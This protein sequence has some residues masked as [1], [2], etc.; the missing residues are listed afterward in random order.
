MKL[1]SVRMSRP[2][3]FIGIFASVLLLL[4]VLLLFRI[5]G[6]QTQNKIWKTK[7]VLNLAEQRAL[8]EHGLEGEYLGDEIELLRREGFRLLDD[9]VSKLTLLY[10]FTI[11]CDRCLNM[12]MDIYQTNASMLDETHVTPL[13]VFGNIDQ[14][15]FDRIVRSFGIKEFSIRDKEEV[16]IKKFSKLTT[17]IILLI[18]SNGRIL[19]AHIS[20]Y[21]DRAK[22]QRFYEKVF[23]I[24]SRT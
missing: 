4:N 14:L 5:S 1:N 16:L 21:F 17:P 12:E 22:S 3:A 23:N 7:G 13:M 2:A 18:N 6:L 8:V 15:L 9:H 20:D 11:T 24:A 10:S 19:A